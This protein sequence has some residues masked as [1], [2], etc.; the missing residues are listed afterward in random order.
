V[1]LADIDALAI[2]VM[3]LVAVLLAVTVPV[4][5]REPD[6]LAVLLAVTLAD[7]VCDGV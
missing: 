6:T 3:L 1:L 5:L 7:L 4:W 2:D